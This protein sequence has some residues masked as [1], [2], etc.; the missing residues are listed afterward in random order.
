MGEVSTVG[1]LAPANALRAVENETLEQGV[2]FSLLIGIRDG[3]RNELPHRE[4]RVTVGVGD[5]ALVTTHHDPVQLLLVGQDRAREALVIKQFEKE[6]TIPSL[7]GDVHYR[8]GDHQCVRPV[9]VVR[10]KAKKDMK[11]DEDF[12][13]LVDT[14]PGEKALQKPD[15]FGCKLGDYT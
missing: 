6:E 1:V 14:V 5:I 15:F 12:W 4:H 3:E 8:A 10:G 11:N 7:V 2:G 9:F 13:E